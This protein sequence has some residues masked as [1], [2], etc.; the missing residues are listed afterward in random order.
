MGNVISTS[1]VV[2]VFLLVTMFVFMFLIT[3]FTDRTNDANLVSARQVSRVKPKIQ[4]NSTAQA[5]AGLC[6]TFT[7]QVEN[8]G[9]I[10]VEDF[11]DV[12]LIVEF[13]DTDNT[14]VVVRLAHTTDWTV[15]SITPDTRDPLEWNPGETATVSFTLSPT[16]EDATSGLVT[17]VTPL[18]ISD[19]AYFNCSNS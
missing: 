14:A 13:T 6:D 9:D 4:F 1:L 12:E 7:A 2:T 19:S 3:S 16:A 17:M 18:G 11:G 8:I 15:S 10:L 5:N